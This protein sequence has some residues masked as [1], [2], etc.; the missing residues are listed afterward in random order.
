MSNRSLGRR[1]TL[2]MWL[3]SALGCCLTVLL[4]TGLILKNSDEQ[5]KTRIK[6]ERANLEALGLIDLISLNNFK[7]IVPKLPVQLQRDRLSQIIRIYKPGGELLYT[8]VKIP[9]LE[10]AKVN[11]TR[12]VNKDFYVIRGETKQ[13]L[14]RLKSFNTLDGN[15]L[16]VEVATPRETL[17]TILGEVAVPFLALFSILLIL[18]FGIARTVTKVSLSPLKEISTQMDQLNVTEFKTWNAISDA[19]QPTEFRPI[20]LKF[21]ELL[22]RIQTSFF[23][24]YNL[25]QFISHELRTPLTIIRGEIE[26]ALLKPAAT[27]Q[28]W[29][30]TLKSTLEEVTKM[31]EI[32]HT[33]LR[34]SFNQNRTRTFIP[35]SFNILEAIGELTPK[36]EFHFHRRIEIQTPSETPLIF[37]DRELFIL[38]ISNL[39]RNIFKHTS[40]HTRAWISFEAT[41]KNVLTLKISDNGT[42]LSKEQLQA[43]NDDKPESDALGI[44]LNLCKQI[45]RVSRIGMHFE[46][47]AE[48]GLAVFVDCPRSS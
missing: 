2:A 27:P 45:A 28:D 41:N 20:V 9:D 26:T 10:N 11:R 13:Y 8:N 24:L 12:F 15:H 34:L 43:A 7:E 42:G 18:S 31:D 44:G 35:T 37:A 33:V 21:N 30:Q 38:L 3:V 4:A 23:N 40:T 29:E 6:A 17:G 22:S 47:R 32:V 36:L 25:S 48:G 16:W 5:E 1:I 19:N 39:I 14:A 46:N